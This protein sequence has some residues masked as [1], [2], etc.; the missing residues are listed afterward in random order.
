MFQ[1][2][3]KDHNVFGVALNYTA[4]LEINN[5]AFH[6]KPHVTPPK[7]PV[8]FIKPPNT[9]NDGHTITITDDKVQLG[10]NIALIIGKDATRVSRENALDFVKGI[11][12][13]NDYSAPSESYYRPAVVAKCRDG[14]FSICKQALP[15][16]DISDLNNLDLILEVNGQEIQ[17]DNSKNWVRDIPELLETITEFMTLREGDVLL[18]GTPAGFHFAKAGDNVTVKLDNL[19]TL[20][21]TV[22]EEKVS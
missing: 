4:L 20:E 13:A 16:S 14:Y 19:L 7:R 1:F 8:L 18:L 3:I 12:I 9:Y 2:E 6:D 5:T 17:R 22:V 10:A 15:L 11:T 21:D